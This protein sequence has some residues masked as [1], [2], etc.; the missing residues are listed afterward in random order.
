M[1]RRPRRTEGLDDLGV[2]H[3]AILS[4]HNALRL[5][6]LPTDHHQGH[7]PWV[8]RSDRAGPDYPVLCPWRY[9]LHGRGALQ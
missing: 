9:Q 7:P 4:R 8:Q 5:L 1:A 3:C 6:N 2:R